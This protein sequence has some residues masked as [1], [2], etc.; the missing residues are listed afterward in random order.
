MEIMDTNIVVVIGRLKRDTELKH[1]SNEKAVCNFSIANNG[2]KDDVNFLNVVAWGKTAEICNKYLNKGSQVCIEG[3]LSQRSYDNK[4][5][6][7]VNVVEIVA[8]NVQFIGGKK[9][10][11]QEPKTD[12]N[13]KNEAQDFPDFGDLD[14]VPV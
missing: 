5:G 1:T 9:E 7:K 4:D 3:R 14:D 10:E 11:Q 6:N 8:N 12:S 13:F 2:F